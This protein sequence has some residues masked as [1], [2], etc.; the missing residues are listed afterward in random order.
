R[1]DGFLTYQDEPKASRVRRQSISGGQRRRFGAGAVRLRG[2]GEA[3]RPGKGSCE[4]AAADG[5]CGDG[6]DAEA[7]ILSTRVRPARAKTSPAAEATPQKPRR[8]AIAGARAAG[9]QRERTADRQS[10]S[11]IC[12]RRTELQGGT[13]RG[14]AARF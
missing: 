8:T 9:A 12:G 13:S 1:R 3:A 2:R 11:E 10:G 14:G 5:I 7:T 4:R 6:P